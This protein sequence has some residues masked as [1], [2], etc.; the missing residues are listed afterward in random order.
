MDKNISYEM[1]VLQQIKTT[2]Q[3]VTTSSS[4]LTCDLTSEDCPGCDCFLWCTWV[5]RK[6]ACAHPASD[7]VVIGE[8][9]R[10]YACKTRLR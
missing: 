4:V 2:D 3:G 8:T 1:V 10:C 7:V 9:F 5:D 6:R